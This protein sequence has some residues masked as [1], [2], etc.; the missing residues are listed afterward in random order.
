MIKYKKGAVLRLLEFLNGRGSWTRTNACGIQRPVPYQ[1]GDTPV[2]L[3]SR[4]Q[5]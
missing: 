5:Q 4:H 1:L 2:S 3:A